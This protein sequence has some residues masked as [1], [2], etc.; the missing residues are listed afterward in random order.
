MLWCCGVVVSWVTVRASSANVTF[1][2][3]AASLLLRKQLVLLFHFII[4]FLGPSICAMLSQLVRLT[5]DQSHCGAFQRR[6]RRTKHITFDWAGR[7]DIHQVRVVFRNEGYNG[8]FIRPG[9]ELL[10]LSL[11]LVPKGTARSDLNGPWWIPTPT[12][13]RCSTRSTKRP[14][15]QR[16]RKS[17]SWWRR[18][19]RQRPISGGPWWCWW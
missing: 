13:A 1:S 3:C 8:V 16:Q 5:F 12:N 19:R 11:S 9:R 10:S 6:S 18:R 4:L 15:R 7:H 17:T 14:G 2:C